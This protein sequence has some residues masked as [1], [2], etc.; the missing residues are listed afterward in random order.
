MHDNRFD[1]VALNVWFN[2]DDRVWEWQLQVGQHFQRTGQSGSRM[3]AY[4]AANEMLTA[5][6]G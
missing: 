1:A 5:A 2:E 6:I 4:H 3:S